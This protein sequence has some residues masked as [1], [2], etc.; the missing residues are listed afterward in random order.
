MFKSKFKETITRSE[1]FEVIKDVNALSI[2]GGAHCG[3]LT[4]CGTFDGTCPML[5]TCESFSGG[6]GTY[7][8]DIE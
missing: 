3:T 1:D 2:Q 4:R 6:C 7:S 8:V 5:S